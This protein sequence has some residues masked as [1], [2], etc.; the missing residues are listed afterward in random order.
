MKVDG[1]PPLEKV[2][3]QYELAERHRLDPLSRRP[4]DRIPPEEHNRIHEDARRW[5][6][7]YFD[8]KEVAAWLAVGIA[9]SAVAARWVQNRCTPSIARR[10]LAVDV[11]SP[12]L[13]G[14]LAEAGV[15]P[16]LLEVPYEVPGKAHYGGGKAIKHALLLGD[17]SVQEVRTE[18]GRLG[19][20]HLVSTAPPNSSTR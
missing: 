13:A 3:A 12:D 10:W 7:H 14:A 8:D 11:R 15:T 17:V 16:E 5:S 2:L 9:N 4:D 6:G 1:L 18:L 19:H 20:L